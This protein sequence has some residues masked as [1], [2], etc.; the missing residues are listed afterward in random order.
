MY[1]TYLGEK[2]EHDV[3]QDLRML[4][5]GWRRLVEPPHKQAADEAE[6]GRREQTLPA[7]MPDHDST[8]LE[9]SGR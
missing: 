1:N 2:D 3:I 4:L 5:A 6:L 9:G 8:C 7:R